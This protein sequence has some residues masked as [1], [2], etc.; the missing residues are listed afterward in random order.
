M[1]ADVFARVVERGFKKPKNLRSPNFRILVFFRKTLKI[2]ILDSQSH[3][4][5][6]AFQSDYSCVYA[7]VCTRLYTYDVAGGRVYSTVCV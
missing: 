4:Q 6:V 1:R 7:I 3:Q 2:Q 5:I